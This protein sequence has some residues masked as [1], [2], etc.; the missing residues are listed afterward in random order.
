MPHAHTIN[1]QCLLV[2]IAVKKIIIKA[3]ILSSGVIIG[4]E[5]LGVGPALENSQPPRQTQ[6]K[7]VGRVSTPLA[8]IPMNPVIVIP[9]S[10]TCIVHSYSTA[11]D[12]LVISYSVF[13]SIQ[14]HQRYSIEHN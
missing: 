7:V 9:I 1:S 14:F 5:G 13:L 8:L 10:I 3:K 2:G 11:L 12:I 4:G 6:E